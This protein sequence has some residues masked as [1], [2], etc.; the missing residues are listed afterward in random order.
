MSTLLDL[1]ADRL[2][3]L[4][5]LI[6]QLL[7]GRG[8]ILP[9]ELLLG[10]GQPDHDVG[11]I[12]RLAG[13]QSLLV[14]LVERGDLLRGDRGILGERIAVKA[15]DL[16]GDGLVHPGG[17]AD[18][19]LTHGD[20]RGDDLAQRAHAEGIPHEFLKLALGESPRGELF[21]EEGRV[22][23]RI[24][25]PA[26]LEE[27]DPLDHA[28]HLIIGRLH[29]EQGRLVADDEE[30]HDEVAQ[31]G[32]L[33]GSHAAEILD[34]IGQPEPEGEAVAADLAVDLGA[35]DSAAV[36]R[37]DIVGAELME[38]V[39]RVVEP[40]EGDDRQDRDDQHQDLLV[41][42]DNGEHGK[43][44]EWGLGVWESGGGNC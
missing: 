39:G 22:L 2:A 9:L 36:D 43:L 21:L 13:E 18:L 17:L 34:E 11:N 5:D 31:R 24:E 12:A 15:E 20:G 38:L 1:G 19:P 27:G 14:L 25:D 42:A 10:G 44:G 8:A 35:L 40:D 23:G 37:D 29:A 33:V 16:R 6:G 30:I 3:C 26:L 41:F 32:L 7:E 4:L 28:C